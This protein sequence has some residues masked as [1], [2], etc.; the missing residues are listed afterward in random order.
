MPRSKKPKTVGPYQLME[1]IGSGGQGTVWRAFKGEG[2]EAVAVKVLELTHPK[3]RARFIQEIQTHTALTA[4]GAAN[5]MPLLDHN[6]IETR[7]GGVKGYLVM[8]LAEVSLQKVIE[9]LRGRVEL[10]L[11]VFCGIANGIRAAHSAGIVHRDVKPGNILF[12]NR[13]LREPLVSDFGICLLR[14]TPDADRITEVGETVGAKYFMAPEQEH[15]GVT[16]VTFAA[17]VYAAAK[18]LHFMLTGRYLLR[19]KLETAFTVEELH[20]EPRL[21]IV[22]TEVLSRCIIE[23]PSQRIQ[24]ASQLHQVSERLLASFRSPASA[25]RNG[26]NG[27]PLRRLYDSYGQ[28]FLAT[29]GQGALIFDEV[30]DQFRAYWLALHAEIEDDHAK[31]ASAAEVLI[32]SQP[33]ALAVTV[34]LARADIEALFPNFRRLLE[35]ITEQSESVA[36][37]VAVAAVPQVAAGFLYMAASVVSLAQ[38]SWLFLEK[39]LSAKFKW[40]YQSARV[41]YSY[42]FDHPYFFHSHALGEDEPKHHDLFR[43]ILSDPQIAAVTRLESEQLISLYAQ[44]DLLMSLRAAQLAEGGESVDRWADF[45]RFYPERVMP[46]LDRIQFEDDYSTGVL[47]AF[48]ESREQFFARLNDRLQYIR[49]HYFGNSR[50][51]YASIEEWHPR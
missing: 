35:F 41:F 47:R 26:T 5:V 44:A 30:Q 4:A 38:E 22:A 1:E 46:L 36:G 29:P 6:L 23:D 49:H 9:T 11:E 37:F 14:E 42:G 48:G 21:E 7:A 20:R 32:R 27:G 2:G 33:P 28:L 25:L 13:S 19:E 12:M 16:D 34:A 17:D 31:A 50:Y 15:G 8:P 10:S 39:L 51:R 3:R 43:T 45:G 18:V 24:D 40:T